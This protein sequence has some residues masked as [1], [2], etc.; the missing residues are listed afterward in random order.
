MFRDE[1]AGFMRPPSGWE[2]L[3][4]G[5]AGLTR[6]VKQGGPY[7]L[8]QERRGRK[9]FSRGLWAPAERIAAA[10]AALEVEREEP[11]Y[12]RKMERAGE[13]RDDEQRRYVDEFHGAVLRFLAFHP[14]YRAFAEAL[15]SAVCAHATP[16]GSGTVART[17]RIAVEERAEAAV[18][19]W[20]RH[21]VTDYD[22]REIT[23]VKG[24]RRSVRAELARGS[25][26][27]LEAYR[28]GEAR[29][30]QTCPLQLALGEAQKGV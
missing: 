22:Q 20:M 15:A 19:A 16:V 24:A 21:Q 27:L 7:W 25:R 9:V 28:V 30:A 11:A 2:L 3:P 13:R 5:D 8:M 14:R 29:D 1:E 4:P 10:R 6:R 17:K 23:R 18:I 12:K 26:R